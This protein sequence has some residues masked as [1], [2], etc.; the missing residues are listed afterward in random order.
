M[1]N[2][3]VYK[4]TYTP[5][6]LLTW[7]SGIN[8]TTLRFDD[9]NAEVYSAEGTNVNL[10]RYNSFALLHSVAIPYTISD[11]ELWSN[12]IFQYGVFSSEM[13][14]RRGQFGER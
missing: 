9:V 5:V 8:P 4:F 2:G 13:L 12:K 11:L 6:G 7:A 1:N 10:Y 14:I 3:N